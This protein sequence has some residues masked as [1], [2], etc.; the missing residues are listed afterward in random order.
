MA[1]QAT[2]DIISLFIQ[3]MHISEMTVFDEGTIAS[4]IVAMLP[5]DEVVTS[6][7][8][9]AAC[10][11][12]HDGYN[13]I[14]ADRLTIEISDRI[15]Q[16]DAGITQLDVTASNTILVFGLILIGLLIFKK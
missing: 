15:L 1:S 5:P 7:D 3:Y 14:D 11:V 9:I 2:N 13:F 12:I 8:I 6:S 4:W 10:T 16:R